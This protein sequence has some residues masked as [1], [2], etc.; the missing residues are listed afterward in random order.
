MLNEK[1][2]KFIKEKKGSEI[3]ETNHY[4]NIDQE[5]AREFDEKWNT[6]NQQQ[7]FLEEHGRYL[8]YRNSGQR[9]IGY[10]PNYD[11]PAPKSKLFYYLGRRSIK[12]KSRRKQKYNLE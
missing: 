6:V 1:G 3:E 8:G 5:E 12:N 2:R 7:G 4:Y 10:D 9:A 11:Q